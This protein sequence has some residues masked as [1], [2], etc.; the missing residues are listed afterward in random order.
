MV[1]VELVMAAL[2][3]GAS[4]GLTDTASGAVRDAYATLH[5][6][7]RRRLSARGTDVPDAEQMEPTAWAAWLREE[8]TASGADRD[9][10]L[11]AAAE[12]LWALVGA[13][14]TYRVDARGVKGLQFAHQS[15]QINTYN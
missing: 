12:A 3:A 13:G 7:V 8:L 10:E 6:A 5:E 11:L 1:G 9:Q 4:A 14:G 2:A 15:I